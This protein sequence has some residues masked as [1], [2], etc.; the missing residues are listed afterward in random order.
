LVK[1]IIAMIVAEIFFLRTI[2]RWLLQ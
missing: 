2:I 1:L